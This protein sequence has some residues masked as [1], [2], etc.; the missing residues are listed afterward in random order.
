MAVTCLFCYQFNPCYLCF[1]MTQL[2]HLVYSSIQFFYLVLFIQL[3]RFHGF[4]FFFFNTPHLLQQVLRIFFLYRLRMLW[5]SKKRFTDVAFVFQ[6]FLC[7]NSL[8]KN[9]LN[10]TLSLNRNQQISIPSRI[11]SY[12]HIF[13]KNLGSPKISISR[14]CSFI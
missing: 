8:L 6:G 14:A 9:N 10:E 13:F 7:V 3:L 12:Y 2:T 5:M 1:S 4:L 11:L